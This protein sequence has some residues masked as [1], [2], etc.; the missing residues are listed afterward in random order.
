MERDPL[1]RFSNRVDDY[2]RYRPS[3]PEELL[4]F[5]EEKVGLTQAAIIADVGSGT[6]IFTAPLLEKAAMVFAVEPNRAMREAAEARFLG[7]KAFHSIDGT[8]EATGLASGSVDLVTVA[9][10]FHWFDR[11]KCRA[12]FKR[13]SKPQG[14]TALIWNSRREEG[15]P[16]LEDYEG[17]LRKFGTDYLKV[18]HQ[19]LKAEG[20]IG[21]FFHF[22]FEAK[23]FSNFQVLD[24]EGLKG[25][26]LS[27]SHIPKEDSPVFPEMMAALRDLF[28]THAREGKVMMEYVTEIF[29]GPL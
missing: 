28:K 8:A 2:V 21:E 14:K 17:L 4:A 1:K 16:F 27:T 12:E 22:G 11:E 24:L 20:R 29:Y 5:M 26:L 18:R 10:A 3:Y 25:R 7:K 13:I 19:N 23:T 6:G 9:Q 15:I